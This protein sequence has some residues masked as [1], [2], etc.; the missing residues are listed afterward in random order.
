MIAN[1]GDVVVCLPGFVNQVLLNRNDS[2]G[3][4]Y[5]SGRIFVTNNKIEHDNHVAWPDIGGSGIFHRALRLANEEEIIFYKSKFTGK[6]FINISEMP[7]D[8]IFKIS[9][10][11][12]N[13]ENTIASVET[14]SKELAIKSIADLKEI[15]YIMES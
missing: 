1:T 4:G 5:V 6:T 11:T 9:Y 3:S 2:G 7:V 12:V 15:N 14:S 8:R 13:G 10:I